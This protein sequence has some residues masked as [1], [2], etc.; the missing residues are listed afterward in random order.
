MGTFENRRI[1]SEARKAAGGQVGS[2]SAAIWAGMKRY[3]ATET[4]RAG[5]ISK[6][7]QSSG[8]DQSG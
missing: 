8:S 4:R 2:K 1:E 6:K 5:R 3:L 7:E